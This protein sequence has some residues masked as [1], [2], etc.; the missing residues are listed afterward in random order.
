VAL[1]LEFGG[2][3]VIAEATAAIHARGAGGER[4]DL[5]RRWEAGMAVA[6]SLVRG[7]RSGGQ[8]PGGRLG[9]GPAKAGQPGDALLSGMWSCQS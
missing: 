5:H 9:Q 6:I 7:A 3:G 2:E 1:A 4:E 8:G